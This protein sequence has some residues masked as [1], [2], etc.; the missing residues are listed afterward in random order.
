MDL[1]ELNVYK[2]SNE[3]ADEVWNEVIKWDYF[4]RSTIG[5][6][7]VKAADSIS[8]NIAEGF[9]R[10][11]YKENKQFCYYSRGSVF[12]TKNWLHKASVRNLINKNCYQELSVKLDI[13][14][15]KLNNYI[16]TI[17]KISNK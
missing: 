12:E 17:G 5:M 15:V 7:L 3:I 11:S 8:A 2:L 4:C 6:Q 1:N 16:N 9:G 10:Y 14:G 13:I